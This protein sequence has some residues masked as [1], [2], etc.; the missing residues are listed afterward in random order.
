MTLWFGDQAA[1]HAAHAGSL[2]GLL[3]ADIVRLD[4]LL[5]RQIDAILHNRR[6]QKLESPWRGLHW[7]LFGSGT[8]AGVRVRICSLTWEELGR[9]LER[10]LEVEQS[11]LFQLIYDNEFGTPGGEPFSLLIVDHEI[12]HGRRA[13]GV[14]SRHAPVDDVSTLAGLAA[15]ASAAFVPTVLAAAPELLGVD[16]FSEL[17]LSLDPAAVMREPQYLRWRT[18]TR[19]PEFRFIGLTVPRVLARPLWKLDPH[20]PE[21]F[22][23][24]EHAAR[25][26][27]RCWCTGVYA[28]AAAVSRA[29]GECGWPGDIKGITSDE[30]TGGLVLGLPTESFPEGAAVRT[31]RPALDLLLTDGQERALIK[32]GLMPIN[33]LPLGAEVVLTA[34]N[35]L[36]ALPAPFPGQDAKAATVNTQLSAQIN[37][38]LGV[39]RFAHYIKVMGRDFVGSHLDA[40]EIERRLQNWLYDYTNTSDNAGP[41]MRARFPLFMSRVTVQEH[42]GRPGAF[43]CVIHLQLHHQVDEV[44]TTF[45]LTTTL[46]EAGSRHELS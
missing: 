45:Q 10:S 30:V 17:A 23:Y 42:P 16:D 40:G 7:L 4:G 25:I 43:G 26:S 12:H 24:R 32:V 19:R 8:T 35:S 3:D 13:R 15:V 31:R 37:N 44:G 1:R 41:E 39:S 34:F 14:T 29:H 38:L 6:F 5:S 36:Q 27:H 9:D 20:R 46:A 22:D 2:R 33:V 28:F 18:V 21:A 11:A